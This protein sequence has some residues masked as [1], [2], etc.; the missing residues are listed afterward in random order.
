MDEELA[1]ISSSPLVGVKR[2]VNNQDEASLPT[3]TR[4]LKMLDEQIKAYDSIGTLD[5]SNKDL[6]VEQQLVVNQRVVL[7]LS[8]VKALVEN[9]IGDIKEKQNG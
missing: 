4:V 5:L 6:S 9:T 1:Y 3:L 2:E 7:H 8:T